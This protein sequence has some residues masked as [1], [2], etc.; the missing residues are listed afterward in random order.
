M[1]TRLLAVS[2]AVLSFVILV[3][4][5]A[6]IQGSLSLGTPASPRSVTNE[7]VSP[8]PGRRMPTSE[9]QEGPVPSMATA[10]VIISQPTLVLTPTG[11]DVQST[12]DPR[13]GTPTLTP[14]VN[15]SKFPR[16]ADWYEDYDVKRARER[17]LLEELWAAFS[18][19]LTDY[20]TENSGLLHEEQRTALLAQLTQ[21]LP[22][23]PVDYA[24]FPLRQVL[25]VDLDDVAEAELLVA[26]DLD[27]D[28]VFYARYVNGGWRVT[29]L[30][31]E[32]KGSSV[33]AYQYSFVEMLEARD[34]TGD[35]YPEVIAKL[36]TRGNNWWEPYFN[37][38]Q[39]NDERFTNIFSVSLFIAGVYRP[40]L[41]FEPQAT[42]SEDVVITYPIKTEYLFSLSSDFASELNESKLSAR[43]RKRFQEQE[44]PLTPQ[45]WV[46]V[47]QAEARW[48]I[49]DPDGLGRYLI[50]NENQA[51]SVY[52]AGVPAW[53]WET[54]SS[55]PEGIQRWRW[56]PQTGR[57]VLR[58]VA[59]RK[60]SWG[61][62][63]QVW[64][65]LVDLLPESDAA[66]R[67]GNWQAALDGYRATVDYGAT[68]SLPENEHATDITTILDYARLH[69]GLCYALLDEPGPARQMLEA[70]ET[71]STRPLASAFLN[72]Y[73]KD[74]NLAAALAAYVQAITAHEL[75]A[76]VKSV[77]LE[78][79]AYRPY[80]APVLALLNR[81]PALLDEAIDRYG[82][83]VETLWVD[84]DS[85]GRDELVWLENAAWS[86]VWVGWQ[87]EGNRW[88]ATGIAAGSALTLEAISPPEEA[89]HRGVVIRS[90]DLEH[91][92]LWDGETKMILV[93]PDQRP[94]GWPTLDYQT[95]QVWLG[96][97]GVP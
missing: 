75:P 97:P 20:L 85:D 47:D 22:G 4:M 1:K 87:D 28:P 55:F 24:K 93:T 15:A 81:N 19:D 60:P 5:V 35:G 95:D 79:M 51:L 16:T 67:G 34:L 41:S 23:L 66:F 6:G 13:T 53:V 83:P 46:A 38:L 2:G 32:W 89:G 25:F 37:I 63:W 71:E 80:P 58:N 12:Q 61:Y 88:Q 59:V 56:D 8:E 86:V 49:V 27:G 57:Y 96:P 21:D 84:L 91:T 44:V 62:K 29:R 48:T 94:S 68:I 7:I 92:L 33:Q 50:L 45:A 11:G 72:A 30:P 40:Q 39:W 76:S 69:A 31:T 74:A 82:M 9:G 3:A 64:E 52:L 73:G 77:D 90:H 65:G 14:L 54:S 78:V 70:I 26:P 10:K 17:V 18:T 43:L 36:Y 42:G